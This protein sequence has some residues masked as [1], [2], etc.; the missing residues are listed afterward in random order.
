MSDT[1]LSVLNDLRIAQGSLTLP[2]G[3][4]TLYGSLDALGGTFAHAS[5]QVL[6][7]SSSTETIRTDGSSFFD[8]LFANEAGSW[9]ITGDAT[10]E[11][12][13]ALEQVGSFTAPNAGTVEVQGAFTNL[14]GGASTTWTG[15][16]LLLTGGSSYEVN[17]STSTGDSYNILQVGPDTHVTVWYSDASSYSINASGSLYSADHTGV[18]GDLYVWGSYERAT[19]TEYWSW[20]TDFDGTDLSGGSERSV[21]VRFADGAYATI[22]TATLDMRGTSSASTSLAVQSTGTFDLAIESGVL[23]GQ[24]FSIQDLSANG[25][26]LSASTSIPLLS[27]G[28][29]ELAANGGILIAVS[30]STLDA[31]PAKQF[32]VLGFAT[33]SAITGINVGVF[34]GTPSSYWTFRDHYGNLGGENFDSDPT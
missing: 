23:Y 10:A 34:G 3:T 31:N 9:S 27:D 12:D 22:T 32:D 20:S 2:T 7:T 6:F 19:G 1:D 14:V 8:V 28:Y 13:W 30:T 25:M 4:L 18:D 11:G 17:T 15:S 16:T 21:S 29:L 24:H 26:V 33:T 5:G